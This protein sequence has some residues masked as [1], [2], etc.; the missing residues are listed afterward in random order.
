MGA[1]SRGAVVELRKSDFSPSADF[2]VDAEIPEALPKARA[3]VALGANEDDDATVLVRTE[4]P[5]LEGSEAGVTLAI[6]VDASASMDPA[7]FAASRAFVES[8]VRGLGPKDRAVVV[9]SDTTVHA[10]GPKDVGPVDAARKAEILAALGDVTLG[11]ATD[12]GRAIEAGADELPADAPSAMVVYVG[13]GW[14]SVGDRTAEAIRARLARRERGVPRLGAILVGP[15]SNRGAMGALVHGSGPVLEVGDS[16]TAAEAAVTLLE[17][18]LVPTVTGV[19]IDLG[20]RVIRAYP[21]GDVA[22]TQGSTVTVVGKLSGDPPKDLTLVYRS[23]TEKRGDIVPLTL[24]QTASVADVQRRWA[25]ARAASMALAGRG[26]EAVTDAALE[27]GLLTPWTAWTTGGGADY[28]PTAIHQRVLDLAL[29]GD[30]GMTAAIGLG[31]PPTGALAT[32]EM[33]SIPEGS[34]ENALAAAAAATIEGAMGQLR[35]CRDA[36][37]A[38]RPDLPGAIEIALEVD[39]DGQA[40]GVTVTG[41][42]DEPLA[43]CVSTVVESLAYPRA[44]EALTVKVRHGVVWPPPPSLRGKKCSPTSTLPVALR[45]G[46]WVERLRTAGPL[47]TYIEARA[48]CELSTWTAKR[49][50]LELTIE[51]Q[52]S[53]AV[54]Q[55]AD[56]IE[57]EGDLEAAAFLR[58][59]ALRRASVAEMAQVR[60]ALLAREILP[61]AKFDERYA[62]ATN[63][64]ERLAVV[65]AFLPFA[66]HSPLLRERLLALLAA[67]GEKEALADEVRRLRVDPLAE[68]PL[69]ADAATALR[70][71]GL[72]AEAR[73]TFGEIAERATNDPWSLALL[74]DRLRNEGW[75]E[76]AAAAYTSLLELVPEDGAS[77]LRLAL[78]NAG[79]GR[80]DL[81][82]RQLGRVSRTGGRNGQSDVATLAERA[83]YALA[84]TAQETASVPESERAALVRTA[85]ELTPPPPGQVFFV[86]WPAGDRNAPGISIERGAPTPAAAPAPGKPA[87]AAER[88]AQPAEAIGARLGLAS[89][90]AAPGGAPEI[91]LVLSRPRAVPPGQASGKARIVTFVDGKLVAFDVDLPRSPDEPVVVTWSGAGFSAGRR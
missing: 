56:G 38:L 59:E 37:A 22:A 15:S 36:R 85:A 46:V 50:L 89:L 43:R 20:P 80:V 29:R 73:R 8:L 14:P 16:E 1:R 70:A 60:R 19:E 53:V 30:A 34:F 2:V 82:L 42:G 27:A 87:T 51:R 63:D 81:A 79:A 78:A 68:A 11:G 40:K 88:E 75:F 18:A 72:E 76:D 77:E 52:S 26:R 32:D 91:D 7:L 67:T 33:P 9:A 41:A 61:R 44:G 49:T 74:G 65:R 58:K 69:L 4:A 71:A 13:D 5:R 10:V 39:G 64:G 28:V 31:A 25:D 86:S 90:V 3:Y 54:L 35:A 6:V 83:A 24:R 55:I 47:P 12:L 57:R 23:G 21:R 84:L 62:K 66:P 48:T 17:R 45:R